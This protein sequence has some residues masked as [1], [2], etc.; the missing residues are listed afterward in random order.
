MLVQGLSIGPILWILENHGYILE[1]VLWILEDP[2]EYITTSSLCFFWESLS[3]IYIY[4]NQL[5]W[6]FKEE[7]WLR[8]RTSS[9][10][11]LGGI[12]TR[13]PNWCYWYL[14]TMDTKMKERAWEPDK[15]GAI[16]DTHQTMVFVPI[17][18]Y[19]PIFLFFFSPL[20]FDLLFVVGKRLTSV[21][22]LESSNKLCC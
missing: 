15:A 22:I 18:L 10:D 7:P 19:V 12:G 1:L 11:Y 20:S 14:G 8:V 9:F 21:I 4:Q 2:R 16:C 17:G 6:L 5:F 3:Y 13:H